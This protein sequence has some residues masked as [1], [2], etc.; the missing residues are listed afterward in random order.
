MLH[1]PGAETTPMKFGWEAGRSEHAERAREAGRDMSASRAADNERRRERSR[2]LTEA[3]QGERS[4][5][6]A[7]GAAVAERET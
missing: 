2:K 1:H 4:R 6:R 3:R 5:R 7:G